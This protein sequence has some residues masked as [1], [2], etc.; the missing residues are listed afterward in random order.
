M[1]PFGLWEAILCNSGKLQRKV[2]LLTHSHLGRE[3]MTG[4]ETE[5]EE[6]FANTAPLDNGY[7]VTA[8]KPNQHN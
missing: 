7:E 3:V 2:K 5:V 4:L 8:H 1:N 6:L